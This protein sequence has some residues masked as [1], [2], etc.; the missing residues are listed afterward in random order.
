MDGEIRPVWLSEKTV[1]MSPMLS[2]EAPA[3]NAPV[4]RR[5]PFTLIEQP[6]D[7]AATVVGKLN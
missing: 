6:Q 5:L 1:A 2:S 4:A 3:R 7:P